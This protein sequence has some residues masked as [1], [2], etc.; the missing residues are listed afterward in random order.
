[1]KIRGFRIELGEI[2]AVLNQHALVREVVVLAREDAGPSGKQLVAYLVNEEPV[3]DHEL[4]RHLSQK[5]PDY[6]IPSAFVQLDAMPLTPNGKIDRRAL[7]AP[8]YTRLEGQVVP[9]RTPA[10]GLLAAIWQEVLE[11]EQVGIHD[12]FFEVGGHS[13]LATQVISRIR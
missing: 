8:D 1:M 9:P 11:L 3:S 13:L 5:L 7:P 12:N 10:E 2:E 6:M 4:R